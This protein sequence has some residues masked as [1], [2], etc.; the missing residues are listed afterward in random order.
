MNLVLIQPLDPSV[1]SPQSARI[2]FGIQWLTEVYPLGIKIDNSILLYLDVSVVFLT[3]KFY[4]LTVAVAN[5][6]SI[7][8]NELFKP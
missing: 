6:N 3:K 7:M 2:A 1:I 8:F 4:Y 5:E